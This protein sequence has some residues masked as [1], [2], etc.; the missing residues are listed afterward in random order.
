[1]KSLI[2]K[3]RS[4]SLGELK[5]NN[6][7]TSPGE[8]EEVD[9]LLSRCS[10]HVKEEGHI[11]VKGPVTKCYRDCFHFSVDYE[12]TNRAEDSHKAKLVSYDQT[13]PKS[14]KKPIENK[15]KDASDA[16]GFNNFSSLNFYKQCKV[17]ALL[18]V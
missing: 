3:R 14:E 6:S 17:S 18:L 1:M 13:V 12:N 4:F 11:I 7:K 9:T 5:S 2:E 8:E 10:C 15:E 16:H